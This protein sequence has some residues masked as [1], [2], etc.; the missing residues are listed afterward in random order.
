MFRGG[1]EEGARKPLV[2]VG[3]INADLVVEVPRL[4]AQGETL[5]AEGLTV[6]PGGK[7]S[8]GSGVSG[9]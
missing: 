3:S 9:G 7:A 2:V 5:A 8:E 4:P 1:E 6:Y